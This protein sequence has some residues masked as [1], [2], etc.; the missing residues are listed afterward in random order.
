[1]T[2]AAALA[3]R[4]RLVQMEHADDP[5]HTRQQKLND[6]IERALSKIS[7]SDR[8]LFVSLVSER[9][10]SWDVSV[11][12]SPAPMTQ[13]ITAAPVP[14]APSVPDVRELKD[15]GALASRLCELAGGMSEQDRAAVMSKL[16]SVGLVASEGGALPETGA[17]VVQAALGHGPS[18]KLDAVRMLEM[19]GLLVEFATSLDQVVWTTWKAVSP[20]STL[21]RS[22]PAKN[23]LARF[24]AGDPDTS[25]AQVKQDMEKLRQLTAALTASVN[26][27]GRAFAQQHVA[28]FAPGEIEQMAKLSSG[29]L[30]VGHEVKCW[31]KYVELAKDNMDTQTMERELLTAM[32]SYAES[33][34][35]GL[36]R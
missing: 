3:N 11:S 7:G 16:K 34:M 33:L 30:L 5:A 26:Q 31:R 29:S 13:V 18:D 25:R 1:M 14:A 8:E 23:A 12:A 24:A 4:L 22:V 10:P 17:K 35:K 9:F 27:A 32:A 19:T 15:P 36:G 20:T 21:K 28:K 6:E 2:M